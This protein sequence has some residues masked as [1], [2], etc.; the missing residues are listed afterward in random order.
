MEKVCIGEGR[1]R[2]CAFSRELS[3]SWCLATRMEG[4]TM[5]LFVG[6]APPHPESNH[7]PHIQKEKS[8]PDVTPRTILEYSTMSVPYTKVRFCNRAQGFGYLIDVRRIS[9]N[10]DC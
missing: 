1:G 7:Q 3:L 10:G 9:G 4:W 8:Q 2:N 6:A 5:G